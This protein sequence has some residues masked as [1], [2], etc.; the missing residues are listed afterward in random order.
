MGRRKLT[1]AVKKNTAEKKYEKNKSNQNNVRDQDAAAHA[2][3]SLLRPALGQVPDANGRRIFKNNSLC[4]QFIKD[5]IDIPELKD[6]KPEDITDVTEKYQSYLGFQLESDTVKRIRLHQTTDNAAEDAE[7]FVVSL[8]EHKSKVDYNVAMQL[9]RYMNCIWTEYAREME[10]RHKGISKTKA[11]R[12]PPILPIVYYEGAGSWTAD[13]QLASRIHMSEIFNPYIPDFTY[14]LVRIHDY[15]N[16]E[17]LDRKNEMS[18][19]M[20]INRI[21]GPKDLTA[22]LQVEQDKVNDIIQKASPQVLEIIADTIWSLCMKMNIPP[23]EAEEC[24]RKVKEQNM[25]YLFE[26]MEKMDIQEERRKTAE[27]RRQLEEA[28]RQK[29]AAQK[30]AAEERQNAIRNI[31]AVYQRVGETRLA[32]VQALMTAY[33]MDE[34]SASEATERYWKE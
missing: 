20:M 34:L 23:E 17:L 21:Q 32:A 3:A 22:F 5:N 16:E 19:L 29:E 28:E 7:L 9:F 18:F 2:N 31:V 25:G 27:T 14:K 10:S 6:V 33:G 4:A 30:Q 15:T 24:V 11:F 26:N 12:Y 1:S 13:M 8:I